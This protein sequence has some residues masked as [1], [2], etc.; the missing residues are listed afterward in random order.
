[1]NLLTTVFVNIVLKISYISQ[2]VNHIP[3]YLNPHLHV[4]HSSW[5]FMKLKT[6]YS[7]AHATPMLL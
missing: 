7:K 3:F 6:H 5:S 2:K 4:L 1:M